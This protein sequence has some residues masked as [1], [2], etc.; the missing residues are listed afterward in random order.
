[1][2]RDSLTIYYSYVYV[3]SCVRGYVHVRNYTCVAKTKVLNKRHWSLMQLE[4]S[5]YG[6][7][8]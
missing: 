7:G 1:M 3:C 6:T 2:I 4:V 8:N 5:L